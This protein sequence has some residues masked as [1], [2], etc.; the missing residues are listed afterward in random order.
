MDNM[1]AYI[2]KTTTPNSNL[3]LLANSEA[4]DRVTNQGAK[5]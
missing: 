2:G 3:G 5:T 4:G 1:A